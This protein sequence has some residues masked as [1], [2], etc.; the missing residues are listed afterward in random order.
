MSYSVSYMAYVWKHPNS[1]YWTAVY[2]NELNVWCKKTTKKTAKTAALAVAIEWE[3]ASALGRDRVLT[4]SVSREIIGGILERTTGEKLRQTT[5]REFCGV[6]L[7]GKT[8]SR[9]DAT[10][11]RYGASV[12]RFCAVLGNKAD[13]DIAAVT[14]EDCQKFYV[15]LSEGGL[16]PAT[17]RVELKTISSV[18]NS[19]RRLDLISNNPAAAVELPE[20]IRQV[21]RQTFTA[22]QVQMLVDVANDEWKTAILLGY[23]G[24]LRLGDAVSL[25]WSAV[26]FTGNKLVFEVSKTG[27]ELE[28]PLHPS[29]ERHLAKLAGDAD[30]AINPGLAAVPIGGRSGLSK[31]FI[32]VMRDAGIGNNAVKTGGLRKLSRLSFHALRASFNSALHNE[33][34]DQEIRKKLTGHKSDAMNNKYTVTELRTLADAVNKLPS[35]KT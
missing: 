7:R 2:R 14:P 29:L 20:R 18:F 12:E 4:E 24:G 34:V 15:H 19:A 31:Q 6:W 26:D 28:I 10:V 22:A 30:G 21:K 11:T 23:Y 9:Q 25:P 8:A 1:K 17:L 13:L 27:E 5:L 32:A 3:R 33:G 16:A 35:I